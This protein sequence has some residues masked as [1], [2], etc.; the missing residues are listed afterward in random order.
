MAGGRPF[1]TLAVAVQGGFRLVFGWGPDYRGYYPEVWKDV[2]ASEFE[3]V[4]DLN[5]P[6]ELICAQKL[7]FNDRVAQLASEPTHFYQGFLPRL[8]GI[9]A[10]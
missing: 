7:D 3:T 5:V 4:A 9:P 2:P 1:F 10:Q 6:F 8:P